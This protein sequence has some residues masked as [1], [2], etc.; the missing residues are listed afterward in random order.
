MRKARYDG[1]TSWYEEMASG[2]AHFFAEVLAA[3]AVDVVGAGGVVVDIGCGTGLYFSALRARGLDPIGIDLSGDQL[4]IARQREPG[5]VQADAALLPIRD[6]TLP[7]AGAAFVHTD[8]DDFSATTAEVARV[9]EP[10]GRFVCVGTHPCFIGRFIKRTAA[11]REVREL[12][13][14]RG[15]G[16]T[17]LVFE[18]SRTS[19][20]SSRVGFRNLPLAAFLSAFLDAG[21]RI[22]LFEELDTRARSWV[23]DPDDQTIVPSNILVVAAKL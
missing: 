21:L 19:G 23:T 15:Y 16:D 11:E 10:G 12:V 18:G 20:L 2:V 1:V 8:L 6:A 5:V 13:V 4:R 7:V 22:E 3:C 17:A 9:L 14:R